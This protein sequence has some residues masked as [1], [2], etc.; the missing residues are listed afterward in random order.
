V[1]DKGRLVEQGT[2]IELLTKNGSYKSLWDR[3]ERADNLKKELA[4]FATDGNECPRESEE[5][6]SRTQMHGCGGGEREKQLLNSKWTLSDT[7]ASTNQT[8]FPSIDPDEW[9][10]SS[11]NEDGNLLQ[12]AENQEN[13]DIIIDMEQSEDETKSTKNNSTASRRT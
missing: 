9:Q 4:Q 1:L 3:Q 8:N 11:G 6:P 2:H 13:L 7:S 5:G 12:I 10:T